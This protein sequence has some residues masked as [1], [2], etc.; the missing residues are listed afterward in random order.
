MFKVTYENPRLFR[1]PEEK[2]CSE[3]K[4]TEEQFHVLN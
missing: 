4:V 1:V 3:F 2:L